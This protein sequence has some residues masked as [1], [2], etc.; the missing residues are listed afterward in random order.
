[1]HLRSIVFK[2]QP[3]ASARRTIVQTNCS[4]IGTSLFNGASYDR[5]FYCPNTS[6]F[7]V[8]STTT[9]VVALSGSTKIRVCSVSL[10]PS[11]TTA[12]SVDL[13]YGTGSNC[14]TGITTLTG[15]FTLPASAVV[16]IPV[17]LTSNG[18]LITPAAQALCVRTA[19]ATVNGFITWAQY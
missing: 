5:N 2:C 18:P 4:N 3:I 6:T 11:T 17:P 9:Q 15:A 16:N 8:A 7:S 12:G 10:N 14:A 1:M 13:V 19:T